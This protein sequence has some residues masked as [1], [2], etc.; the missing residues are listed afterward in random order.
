MSAYRTQWTP[1]NSAWYN[2]IKFEMKLHTILHIKLAQHSCVLPTC[3]QLGSSLF[4]M[5][6][7]SPLEKASPA[8]LQGMRLSVSGLYLKWGLKYTLK[9]KEMFSSASY[10]CNFRGNV[11]GEMQMHEVGV[12]F[13]IEFFVKGLIEST[14]TGQSSAWTCIWLTCCLYS[15]CR[16]C[17][18]VCTHSICMCQEKQMSSDFF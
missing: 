8:S 15:C 14:R 9:E 16:G 4:T 2:L 11:L 17:V 10:K 5:C 12:I 13:K 3:H 1:F 18:V 6:R 7:I